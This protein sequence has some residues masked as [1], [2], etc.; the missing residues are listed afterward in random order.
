MR[1]LIWFV[2]LV[3]FILLFGFAV[4]N[5]QIV[6]LHF[7]FNRQWTLPLVFII[8]VAFTVGALM[9]VMATVASLLRQRREIS[10]LSKQLA[11]AELAAEQAAG[12]AVRLVEPS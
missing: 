5:D 1:A 10:R 8:L 7:F 11:R 12:D 6:D 9:G 3:L 2:R 4:K